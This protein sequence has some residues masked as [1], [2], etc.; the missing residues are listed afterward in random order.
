MRILLVGGGTGGHFYPLIAI[1]EGLRQKNA[2]TSM[3][4]YYM[5][6]SPY[7][8]KELD[9]MNI[10]FAYCPAGRQRKYF[11]VLNWVDKVLVLA[12][13][14]VAIV[15]LFIIY[16]DVV[17]SKGSFTSVPVVLAA[18][19]LRIPVVIHES[20]SVPGTAN[21]IGAR[22]ARYI[23]ISYDTVSDYFPAD[24]VALTGIPIRESVLKKIDPFSVLNIN[25]SK[26]VIF[27]TGGSTGAA[28]LNTLVLDSLDEL[29]PSYIVIHQVGERNLPAVKETALARG[30]DETLL[31]NY[32]VLGKMTAEEMN[33][34]QRLASLIVSRAGSTSIF[35]TALK[36]KPSVLL[37]IPQNISHDQRKNAYT[38]AATGAA[39]VI[40]EENIAD[41]VLY[42]E[43]QRIMC[44]QEIYNNMRQA[45]LGFTTSDSAVKLA[46]ILLNI[47]LEH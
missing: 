30:L 23:A 4:L 17:M 44:D 8:S 42:A 40:E 31:A 46:D 7:D 36:G 18:G 26:P 22:I 47:S 1:A 14:L 13:L 24:K 28:T 3:E 16:P 6:P 38:Y 11:S 43:I 19:F 12:G 21:K 15:K 32:Y 25:P 35:E 20:D 34:A 5:G 37:P 27:V 39:T 10:K 45:A 29:L 41:G 9:R 33:A 2:D